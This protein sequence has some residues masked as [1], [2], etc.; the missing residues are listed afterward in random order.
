MIRA[1]SRRKKESTVRL[2]L[3]LPAVSAKLPYGISTRSHLPSILRGEKT[4][5]S[6]LQFILPS[7]YPPYGAR[8]TETLWVQS[9]S[10][11]YPFAYLPSGGKRT[12]D[13]L[14][15][16]KLFIF[17]VWL[18]STDGTVTDIKKATGTTAGSWCS[19]Y[20]RFRPLEASVT[21][22]LGAAGAA[23]DKAV[24]PWTHALFKYDA[25]AVRFFPFFAS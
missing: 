1:R 8:A 11:P 6:K 19:D 22:G 25:A 3:S 21:F 5:K 23:G 20:T 24:Y 16:S 13:L 7:P 2:R 18:C 12:V 10:T 14:L 9:P 15:L 17:R 4:V